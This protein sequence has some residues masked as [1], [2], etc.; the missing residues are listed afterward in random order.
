MNVFNAS[1]NLW[2]KYHDLQMGEPRARGRGGGFPKTN[3]WLSAALQIK[4]QL[5]F[6]SSDG[7]TRC[8]CWAA[9]SSEGGHLVSFFSEHDLS[10]ER[11]VGVGP[12]PTSLL[13]FPSQNIKAFRVV[14]S[15]AW[16]SH[17][18]WEVQETISVPTHFLNFKSNVFM[19]MCIR[20]VYK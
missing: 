19:L 1:N 11:Y 17:H 12:W 16:G 5:L 3:R 8:C 7:K 10:H 20:E 13:P 2:H 4:S 18:R 6:S 14:I 15:K 9:A